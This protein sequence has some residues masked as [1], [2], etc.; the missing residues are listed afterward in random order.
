MEIVAVQLTGK[1]VGAIA[2]V[3]V[4]GAGV[5]EFLAPMGASERARRLEVGKMAHTAFVDPVSR[6]AVDDIVVVR[7]GEE[8]FELQV[9]GG[10]AVVEGVLD[11]LAGGGARI[12]SAGDAE[13]RDLLGKR[14]EG[15]IL[16][17][18]SSAQSMSAA[19][20]LAAQ[21]HEGLV[22]WGRKWISWVA[23]KSGNDLWQL[24]SAAQWVL[25]RSGTLEKLLRPARVAIVGPPNAGKST[26]AN[27]LLGRPVSITS[28]IAGTTR[29]WVDAEAMFVTMSGSVEAP[30]VLVDTAGI[31]ETSDALERESIARTHQQAG[32]ADVVVL[33][34]DGAAPLPARAAE[35]LHG[36]GDRPVVVVANK[37]DT[38]RSGVEGL[39]REWPEMLEIS[40]L[41]RTGIERLMQRT[42][43]LLDL[44]E[45]DVAE[46]FAFTARQCDLI[47]QIAMA[48]DVRRGAE[49]L[50]KLLDAVTA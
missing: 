49:L 4:A 9:H 27:A 12:V 36:R 25:G 43:E 17:M 41:H 42:L 14:I 40:A 22:A 24:H 20:L 11:V 47:R 32:I 50:E 46:P 28:D 2:V 19:R 18:L 34:F 8:R 10:V 16:Q 33:V 29:D 35:F 1:G 5:R 13:G 26:L 23:G 15:E 45:L 39:R 7:V 6:V 38:G 44:H 21:S 48:D 37:T 3:L 30:V 31:R